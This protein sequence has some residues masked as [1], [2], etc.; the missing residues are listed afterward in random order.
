MLLIFSEHNQLI[1]VITFTKYYS[2][3]TNT[4]RDNDTYKVIKMQ[5]STSSLKSIK[6]AC[7]LLRSFWWKSRTKECTVTIQHKINNNFSIMP[8]RYVPN[9]RYNISAGQSFHLKFV[10]HTLNRSNQHSN[11]LGRLNH[12]SPCCTSRWDTLSGLG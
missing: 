6:S 10:D 8:I 2:G 11:L 12:C 3:A 1:V 7:L 4:I 5:I 9:V